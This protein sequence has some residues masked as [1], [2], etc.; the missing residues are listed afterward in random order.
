MQL[1]IAACCCGG[2]VVSSSKVVCASQI[3]TRA[4]MYSNIPHGLPLLEHAVHSAR[5]SCF[6]EAESRE[7]LWAAENARPE[8]TAITHFPTVLINGKL[9]ASGDDRNS[10]LASAIC[11]AYQGSSSVCKRIPLN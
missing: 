6:D 9:W 8:R 10:T 7:L 4:V 1:F 5:T 2:C 11:A 3:F